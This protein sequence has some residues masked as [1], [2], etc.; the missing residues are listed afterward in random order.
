MKTAVAIAIGFSA[1]TLGWLSA[2]RADDEPATKPTTRHITTRPATTRAATTRSVATKPTA[3]GKSPEAKASEDA[4]KSAVAALTKEAQ[5]AFKKP[6]G[7]LPRSEPDYF[8][9]HPATVD[10]DTLA[11]AI[12]KSISHDPR[13]DAYIKLQLISAVDK[14]DADHAK[15]A[16]D[17]Y[18]AAPALVPLNG[19]GPR[20]TQFW[21]RKAMNAKKSDLPTI[22]GEFRQQREQAEAANGPMIAYRNAIQTRITTNDEL[23]PRLLQA[24]V[25]DLSQRATAGFDTD[26]LFKTLSSDIEA[27]SAL[28][29]KKQIQSM[30]SFLKEYSK[31]TGPKV[32]EELRWS[33]RGKTGKPDWK[34]HDAV[35]DEKRMAKLLEALDKN[36]ANAL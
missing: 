31:R 15:E 18:V 30:S 14:F 35:L 10:Q 8:K 16:I 12:S 33:N 1:L 23:A 27:W 9:D 2:A 36:L 22:N 29:T 26:S 19:V 21:D 20:D 7:T 6:G 3:H 28:A 11:T 34:D 25:E 17:A 4:I 24:R 5:D 13:V 32:Y